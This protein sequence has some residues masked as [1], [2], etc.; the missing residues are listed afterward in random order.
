MNRTLLVTGGAGYI[1]SHMVRRLV[2]AG[3]RVVVLDSL[4]RGNRDAVPDSVAF[5]EG[6]L[7][8]A[9]A[10]E[11]AFGH[12]V[13]AVVHFAALAYV[14]ES[15]R[16]PIEYYRNNVGGT[17]A[18]L[19]AMREARVRRLVF[20]STCATYGVPERLPITEDTPQR[21]IN[22]YGRSKLV[23]EQVLADLAV[24]GAFAPAGPAAAAGGGG[25]DA[26]AA[27]DSVALRYFNASG[28]APDASLGERHE[29]ET[30]LIPLVLL[31]ALRVARGGD[32]ADTRLEVYGDDFD[33]RDGTCVRDYVH[34]EDLCAAHLA[35]LERLFAEPGGGA[36]RYNLGTNRGATV[37]EVVE[38]CRRITGEDVRARVAPRRA[39]DPPELVA[40]ASLAMRELGWTPAYPDVEDAIRHAW[41]WFSAHGD[42][43]RAAEPR[44]ARAAG[45]RG[46]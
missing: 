34:V 23:I 41:A 42:A 44:A 36:K 3:A 21:P 37:F 5:V 1:G 11:T 15:V 30:H 28:C 33:T 43:G 26:A 4:A 31:E 16:R 29:P 32:P 13:D 6:E 8:D 38:A 9:A 2:E 25:P 46:A 39:G 27:L 22:P 35:A 14:G 40:D 10:L 20:S 45:G 24:P 7:G 18:L 19:D 17:L 12:G